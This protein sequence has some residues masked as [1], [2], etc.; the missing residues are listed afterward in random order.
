MLPSLGL[1]R[2]NWRELP[3]SWKCLV[4]E[5]Y[6]SSSHC[7]PADKLMSRSGVFGLENLFPTGMQRMLLH[8]VLIAFR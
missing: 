4:P 7:N 2:Q 5:T 3:H 6:C 8:R 1:R